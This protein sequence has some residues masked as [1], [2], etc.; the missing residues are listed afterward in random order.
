V[1][2]DGSVSVVQVVN[3]NPTN[4]TTQV[5][6]GNLT[7]SWPADHTGWQLQALTNALN[8]GLSTNWSVVAGSAAT[9]QWVIPINN[10]NGCV[11]YRLTLP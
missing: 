9:N 3:P 11:F 1:T 2:V 10:T 5:S 6:G 8:V 4:I 7:L